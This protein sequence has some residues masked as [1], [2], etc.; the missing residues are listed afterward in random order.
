MI[1]FPALPLDTTPGVAFVAEDVPLPAGLAPERLA[2]WI[3]AVIADY[4]HQLGEVLYTFCSDAYLHAIN[5]EHLDHDTYTDIITFPTAEAP[6]VGA[7]IFISTD[8]V[9]ENAAAFGV[10][11]EQELHRVIIHGILHLCGISDKGAAAAGMRR[12]EDAALAKLDSLD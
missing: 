1:E 8:R 2:R 6:V 9:R 7:E 11:F 4:D 5:L 3:A 12:A 10:A